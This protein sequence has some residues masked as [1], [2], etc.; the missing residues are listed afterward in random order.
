M[1]SNVSQCLPVL[2]LLMVLYFTAGT[3]EP[4]ADHDDAS[5]SLTPTLLQ[6]DTLALRGPGPM[7]TTGEY[8]D[9]FGD[10]RRSNN[11]EAIATVT[12]ADAPGDAASQGAGVPRNAS[13]PHN[14]V[15]AGNPPQE[16]AGTPVGTSEGVDTI[17][18]SRP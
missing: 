8:V 16:F 13:V 17:S 5:S 4:T 6:P 18:F 2:G 15:W 12:A 10:V 7:A 1:K 9:T 14:V 11:G 3:E